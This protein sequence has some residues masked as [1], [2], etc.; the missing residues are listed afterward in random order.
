[1]LESNRVPGD[2]YKYK[3]YLLIVQSSLMMLFHQKKLWNIVLQCDLVV[4]HLPLIETE[5]AFCD[6]TWC[7]STRTVPYLCVFLF[8]R[9]NSME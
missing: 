4:L 2:M 7:L 6:Q 5:K 9:G 3:Q 8:T 1:M